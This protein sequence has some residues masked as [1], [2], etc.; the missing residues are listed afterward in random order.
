MKTRLYKYSPWLV[1][2]LI[3]NGFQ[4]TYI[5][6]SKI[7]QSVEPIYIGRS[8]TDLQR[9][10]LNHPYLNVAQYFEFFTFDSAEKAFLS[11]TALYHNFENSLLNK[12]HPAIP[13]NSGIKCPF[14]KESFVETLSGRINNLVS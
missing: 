9:R 12:I 11:E 1:R 6:Y 3:P 14:C 2:L 8:D 5:L 7:G 10:L 13:V 4:G